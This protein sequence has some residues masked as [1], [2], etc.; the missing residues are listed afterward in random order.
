MKVLEEKLKKLGNNRIGLPE[1]WTKEVG[2]S[3][4]GY[5]KVQKIETKSGEIC[6][7]IRSD[8][9]EDLKKPATMKE[10]DSGNLLEDYDKEFDK[11]TER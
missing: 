9:K 1:S 10:E 5:M 8:M 2:I 3:K 11:Y 6:I 7:L 4:Y